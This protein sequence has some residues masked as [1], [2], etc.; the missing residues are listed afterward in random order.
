MKYYKKVILY[1][2]G[3][4]Q[5]DFEY[6][7]PNIKVEK[8]ITDRKINEYNNKECIY[9]KNLT[10]KLNN[11][12]VICDRKDSLA[13]KQFDKLNFREF[14]DYIYLED[15]GKILDDKMSLRARVLDSLYKRRKK[16]EYNLY[17]LSNSEMFKKMIYTDSQE[18]VR[19]SK[20]FDYVQ[21]Q[22]YGF[23]FPCCEGWAT[24]HI[25][26]ILYSNPKKVWNS[27]RARLFRL[28]IINKTYAFCS[29][30]NCPLL[31]KK[32]K[33]DSRFN[34]LVVSNDPKTVCIAFDESCNLKCKSCRTCFLNNNNK[35]LYSYIHND[36][37]KKLK[38]SKWL[39][40]ADELIMAS[41]GE[42]FFSKSYKEILFSEK[43]N[44][45]NSIIIHTNGT[46]LSKNTLDKLC[47]KYSDIEFFISLDACTKKTYE[48]L[49]LG[50]NFGILMRNLENLSIARK[51]GRVKSVSI[52]FV[53]QKDNYTE[54]VDTAK[55]AIKL[56]F[57][58]FDVTK[59]N[60]WG[61]Y[62]STQFNDISMYDEFGRP[63]SELVKVLENP[64]FKSNKIEFKG[65]V[66]VKK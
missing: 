12:I 43:I 36:L 55:L 2:L 45:R 60:N 27:T 29:F 51:E 53:L 23:V 13:I 20:P 14:K 64:I 9:I 38:S 62:S 10:R 32:K 48:S 61:T 26:N 52:L 42:V 17:S 54:L 30:D 57:D 33:V 44:K 65:S 59:I 19:C 8:Y 35:K 22:K 6:M 1:K 46:L 28:S 7:F 5:E 41:N 50:G 21:I 18:D 47:K 40:S 15:F 49:R 66:F 16:E 4:F 11:I 39:N 58:K 25:G 3:R 56:G 34:D 31:Q 24:Q 63:K 37:V